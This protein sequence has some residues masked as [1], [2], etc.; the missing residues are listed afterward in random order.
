MK[1]FQAFQK[2]SY[3]HFLNA[4]FNYSTPPRSDRYISFHQ[5]KT[6]I[7]F[8]SRF[9]KNLIKK[10]HHT[11]SSNK[12]AFMKNILLCFLLLT[13]TQAKAQTIK[14]DDYFREDNQRFIQTA[15]QSIA[16]KNNVTASVFF[17]TTACSNRIDTLVSLHFSIKL[18]KS[19]SIEEG[20]AIVLNFEDGTSIT[21]KDQQHAR[22]IPANYVLTP[23]CYLD[24]STW[25]KIMNVNITEIVFIGTDP[26]LHIR[27]AP[28]Y[29]AVIP[30]MMKMLYDRGRSPYIETL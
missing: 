19:T 24:M 29:Y 8:Q 16:K 4:L 5:I 18:K 7:Q 30:N 26:K 22:T 13:V 20:S 12:Y 9:M 17:G 11:A 1:P 28:D 23:N 21:V 15:D 10:Q 14:S 27:I 3:G 6:S 2:Y 25:K